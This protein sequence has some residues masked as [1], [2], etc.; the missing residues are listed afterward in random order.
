MPVR[1]AD[2]EQARLLV[3][4]DGG[5]ILTGLATDEAA[6]PAAMR[7]VF[8][9]RIARLPEPARVLVGGEG[10]RPRSQVDPAL[11]DAESTTTLDAHTDGFAYGDAYPDYFMLLCARASAAGG[12]SFLVDGLALADQ[13][14]S[15]AATAELGRRLRT[16]P[17]DQSEPDMR[18]CIAPLVSHAPSGRPMLRCHPFQRPRPDS[19][20]TAQDAELIAAWQAGIAAAAR[21]AERFTLLPGEAAV[22][23]NYRMFHGRDPYRDIGRLMWRQW[24]WTEAATSIPTGPIHSDSRYAA[25]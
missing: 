23:D 21:S 22:I 1:T 12:A 17:V 8:G 13:L 24:V 4:R 3:Q 19:P 16:V 2:P 10:D 20:T 15:T 14:A 7:A 5:V 6:A 11:S 25:A 9:E 18:T